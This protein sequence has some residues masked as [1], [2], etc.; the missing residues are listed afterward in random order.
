MPCDSEDVCRLEGGQ[1]SHYMSAKA[2]GNAQKG[3][4]WF[5]NYTV[6]TILHTRRS[7]CT[8]SALSGNPALKLRNPA[9]KLGRR[10][11]LLYCGVILCC[12]VLRVWNAC[13]VAECVEVGARKDDVCS[14]SRHVG[15]RAPVVTRAADQPSSLCSLQIP[16]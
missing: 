15:H 3:K 5:W 12:I 9:L 2:I 16:R 8:P 7:A 11:V 14:K 6:G 4:Q 10:A 1:G 13:L